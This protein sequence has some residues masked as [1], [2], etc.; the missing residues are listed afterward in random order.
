MKLVYK[1]LLTFIAPLVVTLALWGW[2]SYEAMS[3]RIYSDT[4]LILTDYAEGIIS[5]K[6]SGKE[7]PERFN[8]VHNTYY[9]HEVTEE[10]ARTHSGIEYSEGRA[11]VRNADE[12]ANSRIRT[13]VFKDADGIYYELSVS[14][15]VFEQDVL[16]HHVLVWTLL[17]FVVLLVSVIAISL[18][19]LK[20]NLRPFHNMLEWIGK[21]VPGADNGP[22]PDSSD[23]HEYHMLA[24]AVK[25]TVERIEGQYED[26]KLFIGN[27]SH[28]LQTPLASCIN[29]LEIM[30]GRPDLDEGVAEEVVKMLRSLQGLSRLNKTLLLLTR[31]ENEQFSQT[32]MVDMGEVVRESV[33]LHTEMY[34]HKEVV[35]EV[36]ENGNFMHDMNEQMASVLVNNLIKNAFVHSPASS[37]IYVHVDP[38]GIAVR[39]SGAAPLD[40]GKIFNRFYLP[41]GM[42]DGSSGLGLSLVYA[43]CRH[44]GL[45]IDYSFSGGYHEFAV[46]LKN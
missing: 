2:L 28:E 30:L 25:D 11:S 16:V 8:G 12:F 4:D 26:R 1:V 38:Q 36:I 23:V 21:Y 41:D 24:Q 10:Y 34:G 29:R 13:Q 35:C 44:S 5:S 17:L 37:R 33:E 39:N 15:P 9:L 43:V 32:C 18:S 6:L 14:L 46:N 19:V 45:E 31:I 22:V 42:K 27:V 40:S 20:Y 3:R 7:L